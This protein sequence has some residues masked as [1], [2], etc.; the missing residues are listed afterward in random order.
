[1]AVIIIADAHGKEIDQGTLLRYLAET[2]WFPSAALE[3]YIHWENID[4][5]SAKATMQYHGTS[6]SGVFIFSKT[7]DIKQFEALRFY[8]QNDDFTL[9]KWIINCELHQEMNGIRIPV[10]STVT[11]RLKSGDFTWLKLYITDINYSYQ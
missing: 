3:P 10:R 2:C 7:G 5:T 9:E 4:D 1:M 11:W 6:A 8:E